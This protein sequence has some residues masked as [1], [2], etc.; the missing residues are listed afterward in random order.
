MP[1]ATN[2]ALKG[3]QAS[4]GLA[5]LL[6]ASEAL[7]SSLDPQQVVESLAL[8]VVPRLADFCAI[9]LLEP[10][11]VTRRRAVTVEADEGHAIPT[12]T[13]GGGEATGASPV[14]GSVMTEVLATGEPLLRRNLKPASIIATI[15]DGL[16]R[17]DAER[18][19]P[20]SLIVVP[21]PGRDRIL[22]AI[23][24]A[25]TRVSGRRY[26]DPDL[27]LAAELARR[28]GLAIDNSLLFSRAED[29][30]HRA[31]E[32]AERLAHLL[33]VTAA[34][35]GAHTVPDVIDIII[36]R[37]LAE[38]GGR[39]GSVC[40]LEEDGETVALVK[41]LGYGDTVRGTWSIFSVHDPVPAAEAIR[42]G[43]TIVLRGEQERDRRYPVFAGV[44][45]TDNEYVT[46]PLVGGRRPLG[47]L[48]IGF[49]EDR[50]VSP[51]D[52]QFLQALARLGVTAIE[53]ARLIEAERHALMDAEARARTLQQSLLPDRLPD[54]P[55][56]EVAVRYRS[57]G[58]ADVT[59]DFYDVFPIDADRWGVAMGDVCGKGVRAASLTSLVRHTLRA[60]ARHHEGPVEALGEVH[61]AVLGAGTEEEYCTV[62]FAVVRPTATGATATLS[63]GGHPL[64]LVVRADGA[65]E[66]I[67]QPGTAVGLVE[68]FELT[69]TEVDLG[70]GD[71]LVL[72][73]DGLV[74]SRDQAGRQLGATR[75]LEALGSLRRDARADEVVEILERLAIDFGGDPPRD[76]LAV[77]ALRVVTG[78]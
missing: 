31:E 36:S 30:R 34:L 40:L 15:T 16:R 4:E 55:G 45:M 47:A 9:E 14:P 73:T 54:L 5:L 60:E 56:F 42:T 11:G 57:A 12:V 58:G 19:V 26:E 75:V 27:R 39:T 38:L 68:E 78:P 20:R 33:S 6:A 64:P 25:T 13:R 24:L 59:G 41:E 28:A 22:G 44:P 35:T 52:E 49:A 51:A 63:S 76:D 69:E 10:D 23:A 21:L 61:R 48:T 67:G 7:G 77:L 74:E 1:S 72:Y 53:R 18:H 50:P 37:G 43:R 71:A 32:V 46:V 3:S 8:L 62:A 66:V 65:V 2:P 29:D 70:P 17:G